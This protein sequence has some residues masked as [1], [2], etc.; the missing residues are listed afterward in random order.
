MRIERRS[1]TANGYHS[2]QIATICGK[3]RY[4]LAKAVDTVKSVD[5]L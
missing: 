4:F 2:D 1:K 3:Y 5:I